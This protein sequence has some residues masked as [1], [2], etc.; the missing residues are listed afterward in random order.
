MLL[1]DLLAAT[2]SN[3]T[4]DTRLVKAVLCEPVIAGL[5]Y[6]NFLLTSSPDLLR[7]RYSFDTL[8]SR[9]V[10]IRPQLAPIRS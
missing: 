1:I 4:I 10:L 8:L 7:V 5:S 9:N 2:F 6:K 3:V